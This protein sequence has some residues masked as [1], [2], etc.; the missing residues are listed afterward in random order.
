MSPEVAL[1]SSLNSIL[2][3]QFV[4]RNLVLVAVDEAHCITESD[5]YIHL[6]VHAYGCMAVICNYWHVLLGE[7]IFVHHLTSWEASELLSN[8]HSWLWQPQP[9]QVHDSIVES[10]HLDHPVTVSRSLNRPNIYFSIS[11]LK[12]LKVSKYVYVSKPLHSIVNNIIWHSE[13]PRWYSQLSVSDPLDFPK[14][15][16]FVQTKT[17]ACKVFSLLKAASVSV[18]DRVDMYHASNTEGTKVQVHRDFSGQTQ[19]RCLVS[20]IAFGMVREV[21]CSLAAYNNITIL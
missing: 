20:T 12:S 18:P 21:A 19:L 9:L 17:I 15:I 16:I 14:T 3:L 11:Q 6:H 8:R 4:K 10:L 5:W 7:R 13:R 1:S 2:S